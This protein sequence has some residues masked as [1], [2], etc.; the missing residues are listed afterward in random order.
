MKA[1]R[2]D[3]FTTA[4]VT[5]AGVFVVIVVLAII[6]AEQ[7]SAY[8]ED[9]C[10]DGSPRAQAIWEACGTGFVTFCESLSAV[11]EHGGRLKL[12]NTCGRIAWYPTN[13]VILREARP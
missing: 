5:G 9:H 10:E 1:L 12:I 7:R 4:W 13:E 2:W 3:W 8:L 6:G 11:E